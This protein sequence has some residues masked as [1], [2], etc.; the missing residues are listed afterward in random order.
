ML[1]GERFSISIARRAA[2]RE[3]S[4][5]LIERFF[6]LPAPGVDAS[7]TGQ[8][9]RLTPA[10]AGSAIDSECI[11]EI[12]DGLIELAEIFRG[13]AQPIQTHGF[14]RAV[15]ALTRQGQG[16]VKE[17]E[18]P[19]EL[20]LLVI[21]QADVVKRCGLSTPILRLPKN[22]QRLLK[23]L[24]RL[25]PAPAVVIE[26]ADVVQRC[27][28]GAH[29]SGGARQGER[30]RIEGQSRGGFSNVFEPYRQ[31]IDSCALESNVTQVAIDLKGGCELVK[32]GSGLAEGSV[33][34]TEVVER[35]RFQ[36][37]ITDGTCID[38]SVGEKIH[39][40]PQ[41]ALSG[42]NLAEADQGFTFQS[43]IA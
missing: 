3:S 5:K 39:R 17:G 6:E 42:L 43:V 14:A 41:F 10:I 28:L 24:Q 30:F 38:G 40:A 33:Y 8:R 2:E 21:D 22:W 9:D 29:I 36:R 20:A 32:R 34:G 26:V 27:R 12:R 37:W 18:S 15:A 4:V 16:L 1:E 25:L 19:L 23:V 11:V 7:Q 35:G 13:Q 31:R